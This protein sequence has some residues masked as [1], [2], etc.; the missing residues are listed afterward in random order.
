MMFIKSLLSGKGLLIVLIAALAGSGWLL[1]R[2]HQK[3]GT[4][5]ASVEQWQAANKHWAEAWRQREAEIKAAQQRMSEREQQYQIIEGQRNEYQKK[6]NT[7]LHDS[8]AADCGVRP[9]LWL[10]IRE[11][12]RDATGSLPSHQPGTAADNTNP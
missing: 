2:A 6:L 5:S 7:L 3:I 8:P 1:L 10:L 9:D 12:A 11:S 4:L